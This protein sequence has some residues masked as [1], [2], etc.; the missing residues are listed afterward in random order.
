MAELKM[1]VGL[2]NP[3]PQYRRNRHNIGF[4]C[5][6]LCAQR[7]GLALDRVQMRA[8]TGSGFVKRNGVGQKVLLVK[9]LTFMNA[10]GEAVAALARFYRIEP[11]SILVI[12]DDLD[13][14]AG[15]LRLRPGGSSGGQ[16]GVQSII[17][18]MGTQEFPRI[19][20]GIGRP[21]NGMDPAAYVLQ[22]FSEEE[23]TIFTP[24]RARIVEAAECWLFEGVE[25]AMNRFNG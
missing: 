16:K 4:Q 18:H 12:H 17:E 3:G 5:V 9:P 22:D 8:Q 25:R 11:S 21:P 2:G 23:E 15:K 19:R 7:W 10:S 6:E 24:L 20:V 1:I 13:L 14:P